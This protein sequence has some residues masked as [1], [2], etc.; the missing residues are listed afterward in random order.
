MIKRPLAAALSISALLLSSCSTV[1]TPAFSDTLGERSSAFGYVPLDPLPVM[2]GGNGRSCQSGTTSS[3]PQRLSLAEA[4][5]DL[6]ARFAVAEASGGGQLAFGPVESTTKGS[7]YKAV[8]DST[9]SDSISLSFLVTRKF[10]MRNGTFEW[11]GLDHVPS[12]DAKGRPVDKVVA[13]RVLLAP[14]QPNVDVESTGRLAAIVDK[15]RMG[16]DIKE[17]TNTD[18]PG[19]EDWSLV[20]IPVYVGLAFR[21]TAD[22]RALKSNVG[23]ASFSGLGAS[24]EAEQITGSLTLQS[25]GI[26]G[27][28]VIAAMGVPNKL[29]A[30]TIQNSILAMGA[31]RAMIYTDDDE[32]RVGGEARVIGLYSPIG[33]DPRLINAIYSELS[34]EEDITW[35]PSCKASFLNSLVPDAA[36]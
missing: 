22:F 34:R 18:S 4:L 33:T 12:L 24:A 19:D 7:L 30:T 5:P 3:S 14:D 31:G 29:D 11:K 17:E 35:H 21:L 25:I 8:L 9:F 27:L 16:D 36:L 32:N 6:T 28:P 10:E 2:L 15:A 1:G 23:I 20:S 26:N 13:Y